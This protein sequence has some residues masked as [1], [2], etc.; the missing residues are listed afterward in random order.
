MEEQLAILCEKHK[1]ELLSKDFK[2]S[3]LLGSFLPIS[4]YTIEV[5]HKDYVIK[6]ENELGNHNLG[7]VVLCLNQH[8][9][10][11]FKITAIEHFFN[12]FL[13]RK[14]LLQINCKLLD[15]KQKLE[16]IVEQSNL[17]KIANTNS[18]EPTI[19]TYK[20]KN[21]QFIKTDY[22]LQFEDKIGAIDALIH[23]HKLL[24]D[25]L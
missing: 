10:P 12:L 5:K 18:F 9:I 3:S 2:V 17:N 7:K 19:R 25:T 1:A 14:N 23:F 22:S 13:R 24:L 21:I 16:D 6:I 8:S 11:D 15:F 4:Q 20:E